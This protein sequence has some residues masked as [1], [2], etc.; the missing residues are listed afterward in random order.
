MKPTTITVTQEDIDNG[1]AANCRRCPTA[2]AL[3]AARPDLDFFV[4]GDRIR[5]HRHGSDRLLESRV[6][7]QRVR[8]FIKLFDD[9]QHVEPFSFE[10]ELPMKPITKST[11]NT[12]EYTVRVTQA[13]IEAGEPQH[14]GNCPVGLALKARRPDLHFHVMPNRIF[15]AFDNGRDI[16]RSDAVVCTPPAARKFIRAFD[17]TAQRVH[18]NGI[19]RTAWTEDFKPFSFKLRLPIKRRTAA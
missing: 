5:I 14:C 15:I 2:R 6:T 10:L 9:D 17:Y 18:E 1:I 13:H 3:R 4:D 12:K 8:W 19:E 7:P 16:M 11:P